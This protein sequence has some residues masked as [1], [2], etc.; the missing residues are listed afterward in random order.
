M[1]FR[2]KRFL[3]LASV[4]LSGLL[5][6]G[7]LT[8]AS[9][10]S[11]PNTAAVFQDVQIPVHSAVVRYGAGSGSMVVGLLEDGTRV[12]VYDPAGDWYAV[13]CDGLSGYVSAGEVECRD[14][15]YYVTCQS[16]SQ[17]TRQVQTVPE[18]ELKSL[19]QAVVSEAESQLGT[20]YVWGGKRPGG[21]DCS[22]FV[23]YVYGTMGYA[24]G[25]D[26]QQQ[27]K[28]GL[29]VDQEELEPGDLVFFTGT[30][31][32]SGPVSHVGIYVGD[33]MFI[34]ASNSGIAKTELFTGYFA[35]HYL[36]ARRVLVGGLTVHGIGSGIHCA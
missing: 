30:Y 17:E 16:D 33:G 19:R 20:P 2:H 18:G 11:T 27:L 36:C 7:A 15:E 3:R 14:G 4:A 9:A 13:R 23:Y 29:V 31:W 22:G 6:L 25:S 1:V 24:M 10:S 5:A 35:D 32:T 28:D 34:H 21:F 8:P 26:A 12:D